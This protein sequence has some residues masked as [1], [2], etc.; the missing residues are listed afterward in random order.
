MYPQI[1]PYPE[2]RKV[3]AIEYCRVYAAIGGL[4]RPGLAGLLVGLFFAALSLVDKS[5]P[6]GKCP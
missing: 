5:Y 3:F 4:R 1:G 2:E 6:L